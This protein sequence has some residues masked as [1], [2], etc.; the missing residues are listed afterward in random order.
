MIKTIQE[1][2]E[3]NDKLRTEIERLRIH[4]GDNDK[5]LSENDCNYYWTP[6]K[7]N[8]I[9][10]LQLLAENYRAKFSEAYQAIRECQVCLPDVLAR[11]HMFLDKARAALAEG[12]K[13]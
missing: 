9:A 7:Q 8:M 1:L 3:E 11:P 12:E 5:F 6:E 10:S 13:E 2:Y 4:A